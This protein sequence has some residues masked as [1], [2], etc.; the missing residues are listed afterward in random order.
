MKEVMDGVWYLDST[1]IVPYD[2]EYFD[3][4]YLVSSAVYDEVVC[5]DIG[6]GSG[7]FVEA[8]NHDQLHCDGVDVNPYGV[9]WLEEKGFG[10]RLVKY[11][12]MTFWDSFEHIDDPT[13]L[14]ER[15][16]PTYVIMSVPIFK[17]KEHVLSSRHYKPGEHLWYFTNDG[18]ISWMETLDFE[19]VAMCDDEST[20]FG[21]EDILS[22]V[23]RACNG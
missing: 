6:I 11:N 5:L 3:R 9:E 22:Y 4:T 1:E 10:E 21:R 20:Q 12:V 15:I 18:L 23:F 7:Q 14:L 2:K 17:S 8:M 16:C 19:F 13:L